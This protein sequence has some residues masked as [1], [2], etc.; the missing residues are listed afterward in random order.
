MSR[1]KTADERAQI[2]RLFITNKR[3]TPI[4]LLPP[5]PPRLLL[6]LFFPGYFSLDGTTFHIHGILRLSPVCER[7]VAGENERKGT[8]AEEAKRQAF[9]ERNEEGVTK[10]S[11]CTREL[12]AIIPRHG[13]DAMKNIPGPSL[14]VTRD[15][16]RGAVAYRCAGS[17]RGKRR[18]TVTTT[19]GESDFKLKTRS[20]IPLA[21]NQL[22]SEPAAGRIQDERKIRKG[23]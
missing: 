11:P 12:D 5:S 22:P 10:E 9:G 8:S 21:S 1:E 23:D 3:I 16:Q 13:G 4:P 17:I 18:S 7:Q 6:L 19:D 14:G 2:I 20:L 15:A